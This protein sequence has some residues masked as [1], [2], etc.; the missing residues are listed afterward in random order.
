MGH[1]RKKMEHLPNITCLYIHLLWPQIA[2]I[3]TLDHLYS[4]RS[5]T[6]HINHL[7]VWPYCY[8]VGDQGSYCPSILL[9]L[10]YQNITHPPLTSLES[11]GLLSCRK[12]Q[13]EMHF[14]CNNIRLNSNFWYL[15]KLVHYFCVC[16][17]DY[18][19]AFWAYF[20]M[21]TLLSIN[22]VSVGAN[23]HCYQYS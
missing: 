15:H 7:F 23:L 18:N 11:H 14:I 10:H 17:C 21:P 3:T 13:H 9:Q 20:A 16:F 4:F 6:S 22:I 2:I 5:D 8:I 1:Q 19:Y 12:S